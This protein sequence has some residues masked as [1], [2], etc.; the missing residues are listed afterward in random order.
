[1]TVLVLRE[2]GPNPKGFP[3]TNGEVDGNFV[4]LDQTITTLVQALPLQIADAAFMAA[5]IYG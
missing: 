5:I 3:L 4:A 2:A 1:M